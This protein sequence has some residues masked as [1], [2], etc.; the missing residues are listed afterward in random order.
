MRVT[1]ENIRKSDF[2]A[3]Y[4]FDY[5]VRTDGAEVRYGRYVPVERIT[6]EAQQHPSK[7]VIGCCWTLGELTYKH[8]S[9]NVEGGDNEQAMLCSHLGYGFIPPVGYYSGAALDSAATPEDALRSYT[10]PEVDTP[11]HIV[12]VPIAVPSA[13]VLCTPDELPAK[14]YT[15][16]QLTDVEFLDVARCEQALQDALKQQ[17]GG[18]D[19]AIDKEMLELAEAFRRSISGKLGQASR[20]PCTENITF[21]KDELEQIGKTWGAE[22]L[23]NLLESMGVLDVKYDPH[24]RVKKGELSFRIRGLQDTPKYQTLEWLDEARWWKS[25]LADLEEDEARV[26]NTGHVIHHDT[27]PHPSYLSSLGATEEEMDLI[28]SAPIAS[29]QI[30]TKEDKTPVKYDWVFNL[31]EWLHMRVQMIRGCQPDIVQLW[32]DEHGSGPGVGYVSNW[33]PENP[34]AAVFTMDQLLDINSFRPEL[35]ARMESVLQVEEDAYGDDEGMLNTIRERQWSY[36][37]DPEWREVHDRAKEYYWALKEGDAPAEDDSQVR[38]WSPYVRPGV[39]VEQDHV[40]LENPTKYD[41]GM[42]KAELEELRKRGGYS[43]VDV[44]AL[45]WGPGE[46]ELVVVTGAS[47][48][49]AHES[50]ASLHTSLGLPSFALGMETMTAPDGSDKVITNYGTANALEAAEQY[51]CTAG[52]KLK[53]PA[54]VIDYS[55]IVNPNVPDSDKS[56]AFAT[57]DFVVKF[58]GTPWQMELRRLDGGTTR[59]EWA[60]KFLDGG[61]VIFQGDQYSTPRGAKVDMVA[62]D[63]A[64]LL[65]SATPKTR[66]ERRWLADNG[67]SLGMFDTDDDRC[68]LALIGPWQFEARIES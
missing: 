15:L 35:I 17:D 10:V 49:A 1:V 43:V 63:L 61:S 26:V 33:T 8:G 46:G 66:V 55:V 5:V 20:I 51:T 12:M 30:H 54:S 23:A 32:N 27:S 28:Y 25:R 7:A 31:T 57:Q 21:T 19:A 24:V 58:S 53:H 59:L 52:F 56:D 2:G 16:D 39:D 44:P 65:S 29:L 50:V 18:P 48:K 64:V 40:S 38:N 14:K 37:D 3:G 67:E 62:L 41:I 45:S 60:Y 36:N 22:P 11:T 47:M 13:P 6:W 42:L 9:F 68:Y 4:Q 34:R